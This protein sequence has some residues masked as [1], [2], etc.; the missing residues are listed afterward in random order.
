M[1]PSFG[2]I[3]AATI[4]VADLD[5]AVAL[6][7]G[8]LFLSVAARGEVS[9]ELAR[10][11]GAAHA[12]GCATAVLRPASGAPGWL[13]LIEAPATGYRPLASTGWAGI[14]ILVADPTALARHLADWPF[15]VIGPPA[16]LGSFPAIKAMQVIGPDGEVLYL[17]DVGTA[18]RTM[19]LPAVSGDV[20]RVFIV[21]LAVPDFA[22]ALAFYGKHFGLEAGEAHQRNIHFE[23]P[24]YGL[25]APATPARMTTMRLAGQSLIQ[26]DEYPADTPA[27]PVTSPGLPAGFAF[28]SFAVPSLADFA[29]HGLAG[30]VHADGPPYDGRRTVTLRGPAGELIELIETA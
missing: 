12:A 5:R 30:P 2:P 4:S 25:P 29:E 20:D 27:R 19:D 22:K 26:V 28:T 9:P 16:P 11:W 1:G 13:R 21:V 18:A 14:E 24:G 17:T 23:G 10:S 7:E 3:L 6:Y 15:E 8:A